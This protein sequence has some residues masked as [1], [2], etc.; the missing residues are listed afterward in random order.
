MST[1]PTDG[2]GHG[3]APRIRVLT[4]GVRR[5]ISCLGLFGV[6]YFGYLLTG[7]LC[8]CPRYGIAMS[9][10]SAIPVT[11]GPKILRIVGSILLAL[12]IYTTIDMFRTKAAEDDAINKHEQ[13]YLKQYQRR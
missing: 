3:V 11:F 6:L 12:S 9:L 7:L 1:T 10:C 8:V 5:S 2:K 13:E 4:P